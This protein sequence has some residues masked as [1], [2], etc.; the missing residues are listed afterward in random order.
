M[1]RN[2]S[3]L[4]TDDGPLKK[5][6]PDV[7]LEFVKVAVPN[8]YVSIDCPLD[9]TEV[10][11]RELKCKG[12]P[13][14]DIKIVKEGSSRGKNYKRQ[15]N[16]DIYT[17]NS[18]ICGC[19]RK[20]ALFGFPCVL[21]GGDK[22]W[23]QVDVTD[24]VHL[25][26]KIKKHETSKHHLHNQMEYALLGSVNIKEQLDSAYWINIQ[27]FN[28]AVTKNSVFELALR[29]HD[30]TQTSDNPGIFRGLINFTAELDKTLAQHLKESTVFKGISKEIQNDI[31]DCMLEL[32]Q[33]KILEEI[34][35][36]PYLAVMA[37]ETTDISAK[38]QMVVVFRYCR[39]GAPFR[40]ILD[41][42]G[43]FKIK[44]R[45]FKQKHFGSIW[46]L[47]WKTQII[48]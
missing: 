25:S 5:P 19:N 41:I 44:C 21:F 8:I 6:K 39:N 26:D 31:L 1:Q 13:L 30:E 2:N 32:C 9:S 29:G 15:F 4:A 45:Y 35:E 3:M 48:N 47:Y 34:R 27:K 38:S 18:W 14:P 33:D 11:G 23:T 36:S 43:T 28:E 16:C 24:L 7:V 10:F 22:S 42:F 37:D 40:T 12:R 20:N 17:R 46:I